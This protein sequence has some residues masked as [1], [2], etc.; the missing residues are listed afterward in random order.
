MVVMMLAKRFLP[1]EGNNMAAHLKRGNDGAATAMADHDFCARKV[2]LE[3]CDRQFFV[4]LTPS[5]PKTATSHLVDHVAGHAALLLKRGHGL[6]HPVEG[7]SGAHR[8]DGQIFLVEFTRR[9]RLDWIE[10]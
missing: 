7:K 1:C 10:N 2:G 4:H 9:K 8:D 3:I 5:W 6:N